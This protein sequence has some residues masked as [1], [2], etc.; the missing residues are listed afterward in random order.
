MQ[1][2]YYFPRDCHR[3]IY[4]KGEQT[5]EED[6]SRFFGETSTDK[7]IVIESSW[8]ERIRSTKFYIYTFN[9]ESFELFDEAKTAGYYLSFEEVVPLNVEPA[10]DLLEEDFDGKR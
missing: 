7:I 6:S 5:K 9:S 3:V 8:L 2:H 1:L 4:W 10:G